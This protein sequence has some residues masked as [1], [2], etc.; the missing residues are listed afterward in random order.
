MGMTRIKAKTE[1]IKLGKIIIMGMIKELLMPNQL[2]FLL[3]LILM[4]IRF[5]TPLV[6]ILPKLLLYEDLRRANNS[7]VF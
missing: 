5:I 2:S 3:G 4:P 1:E 6:H 7:R